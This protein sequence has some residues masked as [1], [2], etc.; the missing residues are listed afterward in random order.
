MVRVRGMT[1]ALDPE[2]AAGKPVWSA[3][4][5]HS[6]SKKTIAPLGGTWCIWPGWLHGKLLDR[7]EGLRGNPRAAR[8]AVSAFLHANVTIAEFVYTILLK[9][10]PLRRAANAAIRALLPGR[11]RVGEATVWLNPDDPV[12]SGAL[13]LG[14]YERGEIAY[15]RSRFGAE[16]TLVD[17]GANVGLYSALALST[18]GFRGRVLAIEPHAE[19]RV[20]LQKTIQSN[21][22]P[23]GAAMVCELAASDHPGT[24]TLYKN[25]E[26]KG[27][28][29]VYP[30]PLLHGEET[31]GADTLD[32]ICRRHGISAAQFIK[33]DVQG[34]EVKVVRGASGLLAAS[35]DCI[36]MT[37]F[38]PYG[39]ARCGGDG[40]EY[41]EML[42]DLG[43]RLY[44]LLDERGG[45][46]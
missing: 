29:R 13:T 6:R 15:F 27:D 16:M 11:I 39:L 9:P 26:N 40:L 35:V 14:V 41:L 2:H 23:S 44:E 36:L 25:P 34:A 38:W 17:V 4:I 12:I 7:K 21:A 18:P 28:N 37:E 42:R 33:V 24:L 1:Y 43:F 45:L 10:R 30:D 31:I 20:Y 32:N 3:L 5:R 22:A 19:S 8:G 46:A